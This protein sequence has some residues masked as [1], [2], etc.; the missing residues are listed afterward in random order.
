M[1]NKN[2]DNFINP[3]SMIT[4]GIAGGIAMAISKIS[5]GVR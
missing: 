4:P 3:E 2:F 1:G 5:D